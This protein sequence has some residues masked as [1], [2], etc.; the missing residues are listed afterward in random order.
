MCTLAYQTV[1]KNFF[2]PGIPENKWLITVADFQGV[3]IFIHASV[4]ACLI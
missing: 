3:F 4:L 1:G 2:A